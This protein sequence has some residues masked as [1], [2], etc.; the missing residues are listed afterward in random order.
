MSAKNKTILVVDDD[1]DLREGIVS[2]F[3][4]EELNIEQAGNGEEA[5]SKILSKSI[6]LVI[7]DVLMPVMDGIQLALKIR[8]SNPGLYVILISGGGRQLEDHS[9]FDALCDDE[10]L[11]DTECVMKKPFPPQK[12]IDTVFNLLDL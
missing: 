3:E 4:D 8:E 1:E 12:L 10:F 2:L 11:I 9:Q 7:T 6:D 5:Y